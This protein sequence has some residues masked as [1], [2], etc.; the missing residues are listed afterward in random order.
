MTETR[1]ALSVVVHGP[2]TQGLLG[3]CL[4]GIAG[5]LP[6][7]AELI[8]AAVGAPARD[9]AEHHLTG[10]PRT[11]LLTL[12]AGT[13]PAT[14]RAAGAHRATGTWLWCLTATDRPVPGAL[15]ALRARLAE[16]PAEVDVVLGDHVRSTWRG[17]GTS[18]VDAGRLA[19]FGRH[20]RP[21]DEH[22]NLLRVTPLLANRVLRTAFHHTH[23][24]HL[25]DTDPMYAAR[26]ALVLARRIA[27]TEHVLTDVRQLRRES[28]PP[29]P[30]ERRYEL[31]DAYERLQE[32]MREHG[33]A[34]APRAV[35]YD[36][37][38]TETLRVVS[39]EGLPEVVAREFFRRASAAA[40]R[41]KPPGH[42]GPP[43]REG[44]RR[45]L[46]E[47]DAYAKYRAFQELSHG[48]RALRSAV[49]TGRRKA[50]RTLLDLHY[51]RALKTPLD[52]ELAVFSA[53]WDRGV[54]CNPAAIAAK[55][56]ELAPHIRPVWVVSR[57]TE[58]L[59][60]P[61]TEHVVPGTRRYGE[62]MARAAY[63]VNN[64]NFPGA[65]VK[66]PGAIHLQTHHGTPL[67]KMGLDQI[68]HPTASRGLD[69]DALLSRV[70]K[71]D[72]SVSANSHST[73]MWEHAYPSHYVS[74]DHGYPRN[75]VYH[76]ATAA[77]V[78]AVRARLGIAPG[79]RA[80]LYAPTHRDY[81]AR[82]TPRLDFAAL[83]ERLGE[84]TVLLVRGHYFYGGAAS[85]LAGLRR[86]GRIVDVCAYDPVEELALA[87]DALITD[88]SSIMFDYANLDRPIVSYADDWETYATTRGVYFDLTAEPPGHVARTQDELTEILVT[89]AW[90]DRESAAAR[91]RFR[92][93]FCEFDDGRAAERVVRRVFLGEPEEALPPVL[94]LESRTVAPTPEEADAHGHT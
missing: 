84:D 12:P 17:P 69:F 78:R 87:A 56:A 8:V 59:L 45:G 58:P 9:T 44:V 38:A 16:L 62:V 89:D 13:E 49:R 40:V 21:L 66:R 5:Q 20:D 48:R 77:D 42:R 30:A 70:D 25:T 26:A 80:L 57:A 72:Y 2:D 36:L 52:P 71:W 63:L 29:V 27:G 37:M 53:Y 23:E 79:R 4:D 11:T 82:W 61:G 50:G 91:D 18:G 75:D 90:R 33:T 3:P 86:T 55:L 74:L 22:G 93:R 94:P 88:Y 54:A 68:D 51:R 65:V 64:V 24:K 15:P 85:P 1:P 67:K 34:A 31:I 92:R 41:W 28:L 6:E 47:Q 19:R 7:D 46:L 39:R 76:R 83:A 35:L 81:E 60:P 32:L 43:G 14:A 10:V 73:R